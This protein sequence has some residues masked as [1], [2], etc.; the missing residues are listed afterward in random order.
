[1][2]GSG[3]KRVTP[4]PCS[5]G[6]C[7]GGMWVGWG[8]TRELGWGQEAHH[9]C[10]LPMPCLVE[11]WL[12]ASS[13]TD[14]FE[15]GSKSRACPPGPSSSSWR[16]RDKPGPLSGPRQP[17]RSVGHSQANRG[18]AHVPDWW[19]WTVGAGNDRV[20]WKPKAET[21]QSSVWDPVHGLCMP[22]PCCQPQGTPPQGTFSLGGV[23]VIAVTGA[24]PRERGPTAGQCK[25]L[26]HSRSLPA[27]AP[28]FVWG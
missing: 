7:T 27:F 17:R 5:P 6:L 26:S 15:A 23:L 8:C 19:P 20:A 1:M 13:R 4:F 9:C 25:D 21:L 3:L 22:G 18:E 10:P 16:T 12:F 24:C 11:S 2:H 14:I 28:S